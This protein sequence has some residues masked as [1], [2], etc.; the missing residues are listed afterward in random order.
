MI[1]EDVRCGVNR[2][3]AETLLAL[4]GER[5]VRHLANKARGGANGFKGSRF[6]HFFSS[7]R[8]ARLARKYLECG[9]DALVEWQ[10]DG[11]VDDVVVRRDKQLSYKA[12]QLKNAKTA[13][14]TAGDRSIEQ[15][16]VVQHSV[17]KAEG[18]QDIRLRLVCSEK[19]VADARAVDVPRSI[20]GYAKPVYFPYLERVEQGM[21]TLREHLWLAEDFAYLSKFRNPATIQISEVAG[22]LMGAWDLVGPSA[23]VSAVIA[24]ARTMSPTLIRAVCSDEEAQACLSEEFQTTLDGFQDFSYGI[25]RGFLNWEAFGGSTSGVLSF[26]C[27]DPKFAKWQQAVVAGRPTTFAEVEGMFT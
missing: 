4:V 5:E 24:R 2:L 25:V 13:S 1:Q 11:F 26:D 19:L 3:S 18:Y 14:W 10:S 7:H 20:V 12:Y 23:W 16:F 15:D 27:L 22:V 9:E 21:S 17:C 8:I 6:E